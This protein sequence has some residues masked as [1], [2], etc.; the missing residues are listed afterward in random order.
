MI[1]PDSS[2]YGVITEGILAE[3]SFRYQA[4]LDLIPS[5]IYD[6]LGWCYRCLSLLYQVHQEINCTY[7]VLS[8]LQWH[9]SALIQNSN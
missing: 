3:Q 2:P 5:K 6:K 4:L 9:L 1:C 8:F 7:G